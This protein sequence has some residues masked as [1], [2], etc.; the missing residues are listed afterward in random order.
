MV[1][2][3]VEN[4]DE[5][6]NAVDKH[7]GTCRPPTCRKRAGAVYTVADISAPG[8][9]NAV[10]R[11]SAPTPL[12]FGE[13]G[14]VA[15][16][17]G[18]TLVVGCRRE[19]VNGKFYAGAIYLIAN[20]STPNATM[21]RITA[22]E[23][24]LNGNFGA[25]VH[26][27]GKGLLIGSPGQKVD[28]KRYAGAFYMIADI[29]APDANTTMKRITSATP[30]LQ[31]YYGSPVIPSNSHAQKGSTY[32][33]GSTIMVSS[34]Q[35]YTATTN[36]QPGGVSVIN[37]ASGATKATQLMKFPADKFG[38]AVDMLANSTLA[39]AMGYQGPVVLFDTAN[40]MV[41]TAELQP[42]IGAIDASF[43]RATYFDRP[44]VW[45]LT[46]TTM[47]VQR[48]QPVT[49]MVAAKRIDI[50]RA[51][52]EVS[53]L[54][55]LTTHPK[56]LLPE[57]CEKLWHSADSKIGSYFGAWEVTDDGRQDNE[58]ANV[59]ITWSNGT[60]APQ[61]AKIQFIR[62]LKAVGCTTLEDGGTSQLSTKQDGKPRV[63]VANEEE[64][65]LAKN[66]ICASVG[67]HE[68]CCVQKMLMPG[69]LSAEEG[70]QYRV[71]LKAW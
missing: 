22:P 6:G 27:Y 11:F 13:F 9:N 17:I 56:V 61:Q 69:N 25:T 21:K 3:P 4:V 14:S 15:Q 67:D 48:G 20:V 52:A 33:A 16:L 35:A 26:L 60:T 42:R 43:R 59:T 50:K 71:A 51:V 32:M 5:N 19:H 53:R 7:G 63:C 34:F 31:E 58:D 57:G 18:S 46:P 12:Q 28:G 24:N 38:I 44:K 40:A 54:Q 30:T 45:L 8:A 37:L 47:A 64:V 36:L 70:K 55:V 49:F 2:A 62:K 39:I 29:S 68:G 65:M 10:K 41:P 66:I 23:S 1:A